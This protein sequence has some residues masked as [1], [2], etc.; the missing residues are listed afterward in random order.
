MIKIKNLTDSPQAF[1]LADG[2]SLHLSP[3]E[4]KD[5]T[6]AQH[7]PELNLAAKRHLVFKMD[8]TSPTSPKR[9]RRKS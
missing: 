3:R 2:T 6:T 4:E 9:R 1:N 5:I 7:S 8:V